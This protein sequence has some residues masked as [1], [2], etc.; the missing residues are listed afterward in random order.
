MIII[1]YLEAESEIKIWPQHWKLE[2]KFIHG[3]KCFLELQML[4]ISVCNV[5]VNPFDINDYIELR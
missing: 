1:H 2:S 5:F 4:D 3:L